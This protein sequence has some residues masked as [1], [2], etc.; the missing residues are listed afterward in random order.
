MSKFK[1]GWLKVAII[2]VLMGLIVSYVLIAF[3]YQFIATE[4]LDLIGAMLQPMGMFNA[5]SGD[6]NLKTIVPFI[7][8]LTIIG[9]LYLLR[10]SIVDSKYDDASKF[11]IKGS[12]KWGTPLAI[13]DGKV[14]AEKKKYGDLEKSL[15][16]PEG[17]I[18]G[19]A[20]NTKYPLILHE[21][22]NLATKNV[23]VN[24][25]S[26]AGKG[27]SYVLPNIINNKSESMIVVDPK[28]ENYALTAQLKRDQGYK[29]Y[30]VDFRNFEFARYNPLD[31]VK[32]DEDAQ[33]VSKIISMNSVGDGKEDFFTERAQKLLAGLI[34]FVKTEYP[35]EEANMATLIDI[36]TKHVADA[37]KCE[38]WLSKMDDEQPAKQLLVSVLADLTSEN[39]RSSVT[40]SFQ[41]A[42][43]IFQLNRVKKM[44]L[45]S[46]FTFDDFPNEKSVVYVKISAPSNPYKPLTSVFFS[47]M[48]ERFFEIGD[49]D[50][51]GRLKTPVHF[52]LDEFPNIGKI[53][54]YQE[55][56]A[57]CRG[58]RI[59]MH[60][61]VQDVSQLE[62]KILYG[63]EVTKAILANHSAKLIL[64]VGENDGAKYWSQWFGKTTISYK[65]V[66][67]SH[68]K[69]GKTTNTSKQYE[70]I[71]L[72]PST[73]LMGMDDEKAYL[74]L[75]GHDPIKLDKA[76]Q[77]KI[78]PELLTDKKRELNY[79]NIRKTLGFKEKPVNDVIGFSDSDDDVNLFEK[80]RNRKNGT[81][82]SIVNNSEAEDMNEE[83]EVAK[84][85][86][87]ADEINQQAI[88]AK[89]LE[90]LA[91]K[92]TQSTTEDD[93]PTESG[94]DIVHG[95]PISI[96][97]H[98]KLAKQF[99]E[100]E[101][102]EEA[103]ETEE[104]INHAD[105][106]EVSEENDADSSVDVTAEM[107]EEINAEL[108]EESNGWGSLL[109][110]DLVEEKPT[111]EPQEN[112]KEIDTEDTEEE[113]DDLI[114]KLG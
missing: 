108:Q 94:S 7:P 85:Q 12:A 110:Y 26:G 14:L 75:S 36:Y 16:L 43:S 2:A 5:I 47:Q 80:Y 81:V 112:D 100:D 104:E 34:S 87:I 54:S 95:I 72:L 61:I 20:E 84:A 77:Y 41:S 96:Q 67:S 66:S 29:V 83:E 98:D 18:L 64:K 42:I 52:L 10:A 105:Q 15:E 59:Y 8:L 101:N 27:Q 58:Y 79:V 111:E 82:E 32:N 109:A 62:Q 57:L 38:Q 73:D 63:K 49:Q 102:E 93:A 30:L 45:T 107:Q 48:I 91:E 9:S 19:V 23:F 69:S 39:T 13:M 103:T 74:L 71:D 76:W 25:S 21:K 17:I 99:Q 31:Y 40:S 11:G 90:E 24:G 28:G 89:K 46:D 68:S 86:K 33:K 88:D 70:Q 106:S 6:E 78:F 3:L 55:T 65:S 22:S 44:T 113:E 97:E 114:N 4:E 60:T 35:P 56:L 1:K 50:P 92:F 51:L 37:N 53:D